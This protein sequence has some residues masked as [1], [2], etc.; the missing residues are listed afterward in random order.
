MD[1]DVERAVKRAQRYW[2]D[3][4]LAE[5]AVGLIFAALALLFLAEANGILQSGVS[6]IGLVVVVFAGWWLAG[7]VVRAAK[8][9]IT[10]PRTGYVRYRRPEGR[11][12]SRWVTA[13][14]AG[15]MGALIAVLFTQAPASL[16]WIPALNGVLIGVFILAMANNLGLVRFYILAI[17]SAAVG[18]SMSLM[19]LGDILGVGILFAAM[20]AALILLGVLALLTY[21]RHTEP[22]EGE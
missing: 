1:N 4:G 10:Y 14:I 15:G 22:V 12:G 21:L 6:S 5:M 11:R 13:A 17:V 3:D 18:V 8:A 2:Y 9:R 16:A 7:R 19:G 20:G